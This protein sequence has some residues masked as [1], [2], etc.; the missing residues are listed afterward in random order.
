MAKSWKLGIGRRRIQNLRL[1][2]EPEAEGLKIEMRLE[3]A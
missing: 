2:V 3:Q 1:P